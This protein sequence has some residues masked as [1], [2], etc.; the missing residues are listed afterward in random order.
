MATFK[1]LA[2]FWGVNGMTYTGFGSIAGQTQ[3]ANLSVQSDMKEIRDGDGDVKAMVYY[4]H[5]RTL[6]LE[7]TP[8]GT[9]QAN[10]RTCSN[11]HILPSGT[12]L[13]VIDSEG[14]EVDSDTGGGSAGEYLVQN[15]SLSRSNDSEARITVSLYR[16][17]INDIATA[18][19]S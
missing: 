11:D 18:D 6:D 7:I 4:N 10:A 9:S 17:D 5:N 13:I 19:L 8:T 2:C 14:A 1:G 3:S 16:N 15:S 12:K